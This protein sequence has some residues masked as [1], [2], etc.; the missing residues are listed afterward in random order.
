MKIG[1]ARVSTNDQNLDRQRDQ[2]RNEGCVRIYEEKQ[3]GKDRERPEHKRMLDL[4]REGDIVVV[5]D[6]TRVSRSVKDLFEIVGKRSYICAEAMFAQ[7]H[8]ISVV[9][10]LCK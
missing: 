10:T 2:L 8:K 7:G 4:L 5:S 1:Y 6:L 3:S 9:Q